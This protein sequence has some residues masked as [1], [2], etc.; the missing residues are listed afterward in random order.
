MESLCLKSDCKVVISTT[1]NG[2]IKMKCALWAIGNFI[3][4][5]G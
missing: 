5:I 3:V 2:E 1:R 4:L